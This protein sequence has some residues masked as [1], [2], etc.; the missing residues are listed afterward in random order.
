MRCKET[1]KEVR[2]HQIFFKMFSIKKSQNAQKNRM[3]ILGVEGNILAAYK[4]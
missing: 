1:C 2:N 3:E 4:N